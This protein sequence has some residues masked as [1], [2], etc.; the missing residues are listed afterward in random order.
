MPLLSIEHLSVI[1]QGPM[2]SVRAVEDMSLAI[3]PGEVVALLGESGSGKTSAALALTRLLPPSTGIAGRVVVDGINLLEA[4]PKMLRTMR[5]GRIAYVFQ[6]PAASLNPVLTIGEQL[7]EMITLHGGKRG[8]DAT[9]L[10]TDWLG[11]VGIP[12]PS[13]RLGGYPHEF[14]GGMQQRVCLAMALCAH[15]ALLI[16]DEPTSAVDVTVQ[17]QLLR[18]LRDL[19][20]TFNLS[21]LLISHDFTVV[22]RIAHQVGVMRKGRLVEAG[23]LARVLTQ[24]THPYT[25]EL[26]HYRSLMALRHSRAG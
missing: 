13:Q 3:E 2:G 22:E 20:R 17:V 24:P 16:A 6:D 10:A 14:S 4:S 5:G 7:V 26:L 18:L 12:Q 21:V 8:D 11:R 9:R 25:Q 1:Y 19:Q 15:P 23:P